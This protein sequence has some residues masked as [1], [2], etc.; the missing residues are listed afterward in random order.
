MNIAELVSI[1]S[2][3]MRKPASILKTIGHISSQSYFGALLLLFGTCTIFKSYIVYKIIS[4]I[5]RKTEFAYAITK[6][7]ISCALTT[8]LISAFVFAT[9]IVQYLFYPNLKFQASSHPLLLHISVCVRPGRKPRR[10]VFS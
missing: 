2:N 8:Q 6:A 5:M 1:L 9:R 10:P 7:Q 4:R 3:I